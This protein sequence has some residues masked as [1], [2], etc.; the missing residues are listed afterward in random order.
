MSIG[1]MGVGGE[2]VLLEALAA[3]IEDPDLLRGELL[4]VLLASRDTTAYLLS[5]CFLLLS[6]HPNYFTHLR[7]SILSHPPPE[8]LSLTITPSSLKACK[9]LSYFLHETLRLYPV[10]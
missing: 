4:R 3:E 5:W 6:L 10:S 2:F 1:C 8:I 7:A 9:S